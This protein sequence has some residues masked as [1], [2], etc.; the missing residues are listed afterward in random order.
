MGR[1]RRFAFGFSAV[2]IAL[3]SGCGNGPPPSGSGGGGAAADVGTAGTK[4]GVADVKVQ[5]NDDPA[6]S[7]T[8]SSAKVGQIVQWT[9]VGNDTHNITFTGD[10]VNE[11]DSS[12]NSGDVWQVKFTKAGT[13]S[14]QCTIHSGMNGTLTVS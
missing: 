3:I 11:T 10:A 7:P 4:L 2:A 9:N 6:F 12:F 5:A 1:Y 8:S 14:Y 13:Y